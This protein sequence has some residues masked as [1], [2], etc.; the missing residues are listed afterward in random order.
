MG[1]V[2]LAWSA[3]QRFANPVRRVQVR[4]SYRRARF[5][6]LKL[7]S[8]LLLTVLTSLRIAALRPFGDRE[9][10]ED[11]DIFELPKITVALADKSNGTVVRRF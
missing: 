7:S 8:G 10:S 3:R 6:E 11:W 1:Q 5:K 2:L 9:L 4:D